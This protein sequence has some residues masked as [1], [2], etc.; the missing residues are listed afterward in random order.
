[1]STKQAIVCIGF[2]DI[3]VYLH[4]P[5]V[6]VIIEKKNMNMN[7]FFELL[8][9]GIKVCGLKLTVNICESVAY[10]IQPNY[11]ELSYHLYKPSSR[12]ENTQNSRPLVESQIH[13][14]IGEKSWP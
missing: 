2:E 1:M 11:F 14:S 7:I 13:I 12:G 3:I 4:V 8:M 6:K 5:N 10:Q 9:Y